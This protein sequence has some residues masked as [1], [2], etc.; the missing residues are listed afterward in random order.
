VC[1]LAVLWA[2]TQQ[3]LVGRSAADAGFSGLAYGVLLGAVQAAMAPWQRM[4]REP[5]PDL[6]PER[7]RQARRASV[8]G[9]IPD[10]PQ[11]RA[12]AAGLAERRSALGKKRSAMLFFWALT[13]IVLVLSIVLALADT[14]VW[15]GTT[16]IISAAVVL[17][18]RFR[19][20][21]RIRLAQL[22]TVPVPER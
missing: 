15:W 16:A 4:K 18:P 12:A 10:D 11:V 19:R 7:A 1:L 20:S 17:Q 13:L 22:S 9:P 14:P 5:L 6:G 2:A 21:R 3:F 8:R